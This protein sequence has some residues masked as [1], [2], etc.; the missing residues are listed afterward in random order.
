MVLKN[1]TI[2]LVLFLALP[3]KVL[4]LSTADTELEVERFFDSY[5]AAF[6]ARDVELVAEKY[7]LAPMYLKTGNEMVLLRSRENVIEHLSSVFS[8]LSRQSYSKTEIVTKNICV[9][10]YDTAIVSV[11]LRRYDSEGTVLLESGASYSIAKLGGHWRFP[12]AAVHSPELV[13]SCG[14]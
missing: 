6:S 14:A 10:S 5:L 7:F 12:M 4:C 3:V 11:I 9:L 8:A 2:G 13:V 1:I